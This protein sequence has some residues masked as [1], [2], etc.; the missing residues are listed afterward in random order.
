[1]KRYVFIFLVIALMVSVVAIAAADSSMSGETYPIFDG[2]GGE[3]IERPSP[4]PNYVSTIDP[5]RP[6]AVPTRVTL[7]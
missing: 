7:R 6:S 1:M 5:H 4:M 2:G 3:P